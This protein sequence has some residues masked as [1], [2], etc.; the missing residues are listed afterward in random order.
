MSD[1]QARQIKQMVAFIVQEADEKCKEIKIKTEH[2]FNLQKQNLIHNGKVTVQDE[3]A[4][5]E[6]DLEIMER[7]QRSATISEA[8][9]RKMQQ[10]DLLLLELKKNT[11]SK[12]GK[13]CHDK[14]AYAKLLNDLIVEGLLKIEED[15]VEIQVRSCDVSLC[16]DAVQSA[17]EEYKRLMA[18]RGIIVNP[19]V[20][21]H[22]TTLP[23][24]QTVGGCVLIAHHNRIVV[25]QTME[26]RL[27]IAFK[28]V[29][30]HVRAALFPAVF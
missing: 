26:A 22:T 6:K 11:L 24:N 4:Q 19:T 17:S 3:F 28:G 27:D 5:K 21:V 20:N 13:R 10:R 12:L 25:D 14:K 2:D 1:G 7:V 9:V 30:P 16:K 15:F 29:M 8:R 18:T 23:D